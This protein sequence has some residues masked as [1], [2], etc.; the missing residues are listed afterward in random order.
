[1]QQQ[2]NAQTNFKEKALNNMSP[3]GRLHVMVD[4]ETYATTPDAVILSIGAVDSKYGIQFYKEVSLNSQKYVRYIEPK[5]VEWWTQQTIPAPVNG[6]TS[7]VD[8]LDDFNR[9]INGFGQDVLLWCK[10][11]DFDITILYHAMRQYN[12]VPAWKY[13]AVRDLRTLIKM[14]PEVPKPTNFQPHN[15]LE[16]AI[17]QMTH[18]KNIQYHITEL[19]RNSCEH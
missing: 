17:C 8:V 7:I 11:T 19:Q 18:L 15:A 5:T 2:Q 9:Y 14:F 16:D 1:M 6:T 3:A 12:I 4:L 13:N 10:G